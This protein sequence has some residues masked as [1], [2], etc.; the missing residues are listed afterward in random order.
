MGTAGDPDDGFGRFQ[1]VGHG[2]GRQ[3]NQGAVDILI[4]NNRRQSVFIAVLGGIP[5]DVHGVVDIG[6]RRQVAGQG[7]Q[8]VLA[9]TLPAEARKRR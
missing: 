5:D 7:L 6:G 3:D 8:G 9:A 1:G 2:L 4:P